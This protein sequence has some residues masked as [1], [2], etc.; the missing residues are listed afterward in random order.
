M[1]RMGSWLLAAAWAV[2]PV[3]ARD[4]PRMEL[5]GYEDFP[6]WELHGTLPEDVFR[7]A[8]VR[9]DS[10]SEGWSR[11][12]GKWRTDYPEADLNFSWRLQELTS[13]RVHP[14][15]V[16]V[17]LEPDQ[18]K[19]Y[20]F[21]YLIEPGD[22]TLT[23]QEAAALRDHLLNGGFLMVDDFWGEEEWEGFYRAFKMV[24]PDREPE[25]LPL[26]HEIFRCVFPMKEKPQV[27]SIHHALRARDLG[28]AVTWERHDAETPHYRG[29]FDDEGRMMMIICHNT[30]LGDGWEREGE[31]EW[32]FREFA[33][34]K[35]FPMG[36][37]IVFY[38]LTH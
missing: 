6:D 20:P 11:R 34:K 31:D 21:L 16:V 30:D 5:R 29:V 18:L 1:K 27:P 7:F 12:G 36:I 33:E 8:R 24:F 9:Y 23:E 3:P 14:D 2:A 15:P 37:N 13:L 17:D 38:A 19:P 10:W 26:D 28:M 25:E 35:S 32:Y 4:N 22:I